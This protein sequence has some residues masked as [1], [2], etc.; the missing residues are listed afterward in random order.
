MGLAYMRKKELKEKN[1]SPKKWGPG[2]ISGGST[3]P[4]GKGEGH[5]YV[6]LAGGGRPTSKRK[7]RRGKVSTHKPSASGEKLH[8]IR[9]GGQLSVKETV[10]TGGGLLIECRLK[11]K[12]K[13][14]I[15]QKGK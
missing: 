9:G 13:K 8:T 12:K 2:Q 11:K 1:P 4:I 3:D 5:C 10:T 15:E 7:N 6:L 14:K